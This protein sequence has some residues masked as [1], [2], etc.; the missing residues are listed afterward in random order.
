MPFTLATT[1]LLQFAKATA[2]NQSFNASTLS[3]FFNTR[4]LA[5]CATTTAGCYY[6]SKPMDNLQQGKPNSYALERGL[7]TRGFKIQQIEKK[8]K[9]NE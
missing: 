9:V 8:Y 6:M 3:S 5:L 7:S 1:G 4:V 2:Q